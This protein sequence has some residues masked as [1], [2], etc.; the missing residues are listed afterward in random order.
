MMQDVAGDDVLSFDEIEAA[1]MDAMD[2]LGR[3]PDRE[4]G[5]LSA[6][7]RSS[8]PEIIRSTWYGDYGDEDEEPRGPGLT[9]VQVD[10]VER[11]LS[12]SSAFLLNVAPAHRRLVG[13]VLRIKRQDEGGGFEWSDVWRIFGDRTVTSDALRKRYERAIR[14]V[15][16]AVNGSAMARA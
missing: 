2:Y 4:R 13:I 14:K 10:H 15:A 1:L 7:S 12:G 9:R 8:W 11:W 5:F 6:G 3:M 16:Q